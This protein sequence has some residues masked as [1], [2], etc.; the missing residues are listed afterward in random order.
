[1]R[2]KSVKRVGFAWYSVKN[3]I[4]SFRKFTIC[5]FVLNFFDKTSKHSRSKVISKSYTP[6]KKKSLYFKFRVYHTNIC[7][8]RRFYLLINDKINILFLKNRE[9]TRQ[10]PQIKSVMAHTLPLKHFACSTLH[11]WMHGEYIRKLILLAR[12]I[13][14]FCAFSHTTHTRFA[15]IH[16]INWGTL[17]YKAIDLNHTIFHAHEPLHKAYYLERFLVI[18]SVTKIT[19]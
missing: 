9:Y 19:I 13:L 12:Q 7:K 11:I 18:F 14:S 3:L 8:T 6:W 16:Q 2:Y 5:Q 1:M 10:S 4:F 15:Y 17:L